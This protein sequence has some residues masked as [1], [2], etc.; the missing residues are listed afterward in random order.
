[1]KNILEELYYGNIES[2]ARKHK[3]NSASMN[4]LKRINNLEKELL[5]TLTEKQQGLL[6]ELQASQDELTS[7]VELDSFII[8]FRLGAQFIYDTFLNNEAL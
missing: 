8:A 6:N 7:I 5:S 1:M 4:I 3:K 2:L